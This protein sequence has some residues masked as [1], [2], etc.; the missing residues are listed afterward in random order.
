MLELVALA[1][2]AGLSAAHAITAYLREQ[3]FQAERDAWRTERS[4]LLNR[5]KP[6]TAQ[7]VIAPVKDPPAVDLFSDDDYWDARGIRPAPEVDPGEPITEE[8]EV[9]PW[10]P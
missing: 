10:R 7:P 1:V 3:A 2:V 8:H 6:E 5:I 9:I 4:E